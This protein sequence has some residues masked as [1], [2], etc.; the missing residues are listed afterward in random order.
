MDPW[1]FAFSYSW[2]DFESKENPQFDPLL[3]PNSPEHTFRTGLEYI[4]ERWDAD[5]SVRWVD[6]F[7][8]SV[9]V[10]NGPVES[11]TTVDLNV[12]FRVV[13]HWKVGTN[14]SNLFDSVHYESF[15]GDLLRRRALVYVAFDWQN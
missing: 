12:N 13:D 10:F 15:G 9:G 1:R 6:D 2:F 5:F 14:I 4:A 8:W 11:Y 7:L 3:A